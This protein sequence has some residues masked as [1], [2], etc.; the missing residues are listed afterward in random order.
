MIKI[1]LIKGKPPSENQI[2]EINLNRHTDS[3]TIWYLI[4][5]LAAKHDLHYGQGCAVVSLDNK[6]LHVYD[7]V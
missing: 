5:E 7:L 1:Q 2:A 6:T 4:K 3:V